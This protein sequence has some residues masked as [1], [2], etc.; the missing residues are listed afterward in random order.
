MSLGASSPEPD[1][2]PVKAGTEQE[3]R[4]RR[5]LIEQ[6]EAFHR[7]S[8]RK[9]FRIADLEQRIEEIVR[10]YEGSLSWRLT[11]PLRIVKRVLRRR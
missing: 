10:S 2:S 1:E 4:L 3:E 11:A 8:M 5:Q 9:A 6:R 7:E